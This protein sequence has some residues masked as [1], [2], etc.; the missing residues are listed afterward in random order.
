[1]PAGGSASCTITNDD[2]AGTLTVNKVV[3]NDNGGEAT[4]DD[5]SF[6]VNGGASQA[7]EADGSN[8]LTVDA[9]TYNVTETPIDGYTMTGNTCVDVV[10]PNGGSASCTITNDDTKASP[11]GTTVQRWVLHDSLTI[12]GLRAGAPD[13]A[14]ATVT[15]SVFSDDECA[16]QVGDD[17]V[18]DLVGSSAS[19]ALG[20]EVFESGTYYWTA[21]YSGDAYNDVF[22]TACGDEITQILAKDAFGGVRDDFAV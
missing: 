10:V 15:F 21:D 1:M 20:V 2:D 11:A 14:D 16:E 13:A 5:F 7:F 17:E 3:V 18:I 12:T 4:P 22:S 8:D 9:G 6:E 19:T